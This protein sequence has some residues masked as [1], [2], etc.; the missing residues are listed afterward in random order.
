MVDSCDTTKD[1]ANHA[2]STAVSISL[3]WAHGV[4]TH[5]RKHVHVI[6]S[7]VAVTTPAV[8]QGHAWLESNNGK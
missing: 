7:N 8:G 3:T 6:G 5:E 2:G 1:L 4:D